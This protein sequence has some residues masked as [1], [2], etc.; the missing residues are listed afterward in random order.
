MGEGV[1]GPGDLDN[2]SLTLLIGLRLSQRIMASLHVED[3]GE[4]PQ[5]L[6]LLT[7]A[8]SP[9]PEEHGCHAIEQLLSF[10]HVF[11]R[12]VSPGNSHPQGSPGF[13]VRPRGR[14]EPCDAMS[15]LTLVAFGD[16]EC[17]R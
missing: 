4:D 1:L 17:N 7:S 10:L 15:A 16:V 8:S 9:E 11:G 12:D 5:I 6:A 3:E 13:T 2:T 14:G